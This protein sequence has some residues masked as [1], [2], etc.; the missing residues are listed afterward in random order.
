[1]PS[2]RLS[3]ALFVVQSSNNRSAIAL[4]WICDRAAIAQQL[5]SNKSVIAMQLLYYRLQL[6]CNLFAIDLK[7]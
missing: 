4:K 1:L 2:G 5:L 6:L 7:S 3:I